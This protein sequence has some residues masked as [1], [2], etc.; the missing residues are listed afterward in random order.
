MASAYPQ[1]LAS[2][3]PNNWTFDAIFTAQSDLRIANGSLSKA[4]LQ[5]ENVRR[6][7]SAS[8]QEIQAAAD[9]LNT[10]IE[11]H[12]ESKAQADQVVERLKPILNSD[13]RTLHPLFFEQGDFRSVNVQPGITNTP[14]SAGKINSYKG[15]MEQLETQTI[16]LARRLQAEAKAKRIELLLLLKQKQGEQDSV[17]AVNTRE[18]IAEQQ[19]DLRN[20]D[21]DDGTVTA[22]PAANSA[23]SELSDG[24]DKFQDQDLVLL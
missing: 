6:N 18:A 14:L 1:R 8:V 2:I 5:A 24:R 21:S 23:S 11:L 10:D 9:S 19:D 22:I 7:T 4:I 12:F 20:K 3:D 13:A 16:P 15:S 17:N